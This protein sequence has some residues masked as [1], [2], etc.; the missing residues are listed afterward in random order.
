MEKR[1]KFG[2]IDIASGIWL[3]LAGYTAVILAGLLLFYFAAVSTFVNRF[4]KL[5]RQAEALGTK[6]MQ[7]SSFDVIGRNM[8]QV[9]EKTEEMLSG[10]ENSL[11]GTQMSHNSMLDQISDISIK[12]KIRLEKM[13]PVEIGKK[14]FWELSF[15]ADYAGI[16]DFMSELEKYFRVETLRITSGQA[17]SS[18]SK[19]ELRVSLLAGQVY[20]GEFR[21]KSSEKDIFELYDEV[22]Y[23]LKDIQAKEV[24]N[25][26]YVLLKTRDPMSYSDTIFP[27]E[28]KIEVKKE[29]KKVEKKVVV[30]E[31]PPVTIEGIYWDPTMPIVVIR[32][33]AMREGE[34]VNGVQIEKIY[35]D[36]VTVLWKN[37]K[38]D[39]KK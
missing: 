9:R 22:T 14:K 7:Y 32:G 24:E 1:I 13:A 38:Y 29:E 5:S 33:N 17:S 34:E 6:S 37:R 11:A 35:E 39:L 23:L 16:C 8:Q 30:V 36:K 18:E 19:V 15:S 2:K 10:Y 28:K 12:S 21:K 25:A 26:S 3:K 27:V 4:S 20:G 31:R